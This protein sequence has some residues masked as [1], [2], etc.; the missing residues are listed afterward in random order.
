VEE[1]AKTITVVGLGAGDFNQIT[2]GTYQLLKDAE[3]LYLRTKD[4]PVIRNLEKERISFASFDELYEQ[5]ESFQE[6]YD[7]IVAFLIE[8]ACSQNI[9]YAVPGHPLVAEQTVQMLLERQDESGVNVVIKGGQSFIDPILTTLRI[10]PIEGLQLLDGTSLRKEELQLEQHII[11]AQVYDSFVASEIK[12]TLMERYPDD[13]QVVIVTAAG[14]S[15][16]RIQ[17]VKLLELDRIVGLNNLTAVYV[18]PVQDET[19][20]EREFYTLRKVIQILRGPDGC[21]W[22][23]KQTHHS[24]KKY[25]IEETYEV[26]EAIDEEDDEHLVEELGDVL[27]QVLLHAQIGEDEG[28]FTIDDIIGVLTRKMIRRHPHVFGESKLDTAEEVKQS[29]DEIKKEERDN[30]QPD[31]LLT[32][33][34]KGLPSLYRAYEYQKKAAKVGFDWDEVE[35]IWEKVRE[36]LKE[37]QQALKTDNDKEIEGEFGDILFALVNLARYYKI[38]PEQALESTNRKFYERFVYI[39]RALQ[40]QNAKFEEM[41]LDQL[42]ALWEKAKKS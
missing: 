16:E 34:T 3:T 15:E 7:S 19:F 29:W 22:D 10:D 21:P 4:H 38:D 32:G 41:N 11:I 31:S 27:L 5:H 2:M 13:Y 40:T 17:S 35:P 6:V 20:L 42:D 28:Y 24:L 14:S 37:F 1:M 25:L 18:P 30:A 36:E 12:L 9:V 33:V 23:Q 39:E 26:L 8:K